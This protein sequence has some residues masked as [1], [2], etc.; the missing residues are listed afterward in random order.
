MKRLYKTL[1]IAIIL[2]GVFYGF[3]A[4]KKYSVVEADIEKVKA[5]KGD[6]EIMFN[7]TGYIQPKIVREVYSPVSG[8]ISEMFFKEGDEVKEGDKLL[9][10]QPGSSAADKFVPIEIKSPI[11]GVVMP[12]SSDDGYS[13]RTSEIKKVGE[14]I[15]G[16]ADYNPTCVMKIANMERMIA[17]VEVN[18]VDILKIKK[19]MKVDITIDAV[20]QKVKGKISTISLASSLNSKTYPV[21][22]E[23]DQKINALPNMT[24]RITASIEKK[25]GIIKIPIS[26]L[27]NE[28]GANFVYVYNPKTKKAKKTPVLTGIRNDTD[29]EILSGV[30]EGDELYTDK[31]LNIESE[32]DKT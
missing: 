20:N 7:E 10:V 23:I 5:E 2:S 22:I 16:Q 13:N 30:K 15:T 32:N 24:A 6:I 9:V 31:P 28:Y 14:R 19:G 12:C 21:E 29:V 1:I 11:N 4:Y 25:S 17:K 26:A 8:V 3:K 27:F 18:E